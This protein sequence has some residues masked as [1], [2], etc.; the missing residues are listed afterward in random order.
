MIVFDFKKCAFQF[1][2]F[3]TPLPVLHSCTGKNNM[4]LIFRIMLLQ[5]YK[6]NPHD[7]EMEYW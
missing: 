7:T 4:K 6:K 2:K 1:G 5:V 3:H